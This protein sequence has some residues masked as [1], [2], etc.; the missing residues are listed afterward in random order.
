MKK[1][2]CLVLAL[3]LALSLVACGGDTSTNDA[4]TNDAAATGDTATG[5]T[6]GAEVLK[7]GGIGPLTGAAAQYGNAVK[8][9]AEIAVEEINALGGLQ[10][11]LNFQDDEGDPEKSI[12][13]YNNLKDWEMD[14]VFGPVTTNPAVAVAGEA[15][16]DGYFML[17][18]TASSESVIEVGDKIFRLCFADP[19]QGVAIADYIAENMADSTIG[20]LYDSS[21]AYSSGI[22]DAFVAE[23]SAK[24]LN[25]VGT[26]AFT[27]DSKSDFTTQ[28][29]L[30][31][32]KGVDLLVCPFYY[33]E[34]SLVM[35]Q[36]DKMG[37]DLT[38]FGADGMDGVLG[39]ANFDTALAEGAYLMTP[40]SATSEDEATQSF[41]AKYTEKTGEV[42]SQFAA[43]GYDCIYAIYQAAM[44]GGYTSDM[45]TEQVAELMVGQFT[46]MSIT[47]LTGDM[48]WQENGAVT[49]A[50]H[51]YVIT[52]GA[53]AAA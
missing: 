16:N 10:I 40:F 43:D 18:G 50:P 33:S 28:L 51:A 19:E 13:A 49:K 8:N 6:T 1:I 45:T 39:V 32:S 30:F 27:A 29:Q 3:A 53:Y 26:E 31:Q 14:L 2:L 34:I 36:A 44:N 25:V 48:T 23:A 41:T 12:N 17:T 15:Q 11:E 5:D 20:V 9:G 21:D 47:G 7:I 46:T 4:S 22:Y 24:G 35:T 38:F 37:Y 42:P 52:D